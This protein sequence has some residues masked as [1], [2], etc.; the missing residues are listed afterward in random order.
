M[1]ASKGQEGKQH[2]G[3]DGQDD[4]YKRGNDEADENHADEFLQLRGG[5]HG[6][7]D[8]LLW[9]IATAIDLWAGIDTDEQGG[10]LD[11]GHAEL[12][13]YAGEGAMAK[14]Q[15]ENPRYKG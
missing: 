6:K 15:I 5:K 8:S 13:I 12:W 3:S 7:I 10:C 11:Q 2:V 1:V 4:E 14:C 9:K